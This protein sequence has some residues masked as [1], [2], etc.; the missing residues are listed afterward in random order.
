MDLFWGED[1][2]L[3]SGWRFLLSVFF[4]LVVNSFAVDLA[5]SWAGPND[6]KFELLYR[7]LLMIFLLVAFS[8]LLKTLDRV[9]GNPLP[10]MGLGSQHL[11]HDAVLGFVAG[12]AMVGLSVLPIAIGY[13]L[14]FH[15]VLSWH[16]L[17]LA[18]S[19]LFILAT[20]A[21]AEEAA[22]RGYPFQRLVDATGG[23]AA[24][25]L[26][27]VLFGVVHLRNPH[28]SIFSLINT[29]VIGIVLALAYLRTRS[30][31]LP[32]GLHFGWNVTLGL[33]FGLPVSGI[34]QFAVL[35]RGTADGP[36]WV[37]GGAYGIEG[38]AAG[39]LGIVAGLCFLV[40]GL[41]SRPKLALQD[42]GDEKSKTGSD[43]GGI[44]LSQ[45]SGAPG[46]G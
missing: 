24:I 31:W 6:R 21:M 41:K 37:T 45:G 3:R 29:L 33:V 4:F 18:C 35:V 20:G 42:F 46:T 15:V 34:P 7:P 28:S 27:S 25:V 39:T 5:N 16:S 23:V 10:A 40:I 8:V 19:V 2:R 36:A 17:K 32:W 9:D 38:G 11:A 22:F 30:L 44:Q 13:H 43:S 12:A 14:G 1:G 26:S